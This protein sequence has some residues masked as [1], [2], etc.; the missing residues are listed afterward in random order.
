MNPDNF[1]KQIERA[2]LRQPPAEWRAEILSVARANIRTPA[3]SEAGLL[4]SLRELL[5]RIPAAWSAIAAV[6]LVIIGVNALLLESP[7]TGAASGFAAA[8]SDGPTI[9]NLQR[10]EIRLLADHLNTVSEP[11][12]PRPQP[13]P[14][15]RSDRRRE[16][17]FGEIQSEIQRSPFA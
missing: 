13:V 10:A 2:P 11:P 5:A 17:G 4:T 9:W 15:P 1:E 7:P 14:A 6:W 3:A 8:F 12:Q 16:D